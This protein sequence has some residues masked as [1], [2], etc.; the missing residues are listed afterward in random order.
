MYTRLQPYAIQAAGCRLGTC[1]SHMGVRLGDPRWL[2]PGP[3]LHIL[4]MHTLYRATP[5]P[6]RPRG[7]MGKS[8]STAVLQADRPYYRPT[9][10]LTSTAVL[11]ALLQ[12]VLQAL[13]QAVLEALL[14]ALL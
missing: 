10:G 4:Y 2:V 3:T 6:T 1:G 5:K 9:R 11:E 8:W 12:A 7:P 14:Q 13:Q